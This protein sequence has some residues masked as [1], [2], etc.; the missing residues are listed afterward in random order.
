MNVQV[1]NNLAR[2]IIA[3]DRPNNR[4]D[5]SQPL[6][7]TVK[8]D[9]LRQY[10]HLPIVE[11]AK[12]LGTCTT[13]LKKIC[14]KNKIKKWPYRQIR[15][16]TKSVQSLEMASMN[17]SL[18]EDLR[19]QYREQIATLQRAIDDLIRDPN[20]SINLVDMRVPVEEND[21]QDI[22]DP[23]SGTGSSYPT[24]RSDGMIDNSTPS[25]WATEQAAAFSAASGSSPNIPLSAAMA[26]QQQVAVSTS[27][28]LILQPSADVNQIMLAAAATA[29][30]EATSR[31]ASSMIKR[32]TSSSNGSS[33]AINQLGTGNTSGDGGA[34]DGQGGAKQKP[35]LLQ[36]QQ[37]QQPP[38]QEE[39]I[40]NNPLIGTTIVSQLTYTN[41][42]RHRIIY[43]PPVH[44]APLQR[45]KLNTSK[46]L[47]PLIE[48]D[49]CNNFDMDFLPQSILKKGDGGLSG[50]LPVSSYAEGG[51][52]EA[53]GG[54]GMDTSSQT[55]GGGGGN[56]MGMS[57]HSG[58]SYQDMGDA[59]RGSL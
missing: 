34:V 22:G 37:Q 55:S 28:K 4:T 35:Q 15:S 46:K 14:R 26:S 25:L 50:S 57:N 12:Q 41:P 24:S 54:S 11:V 59:Y 8:L 20:T 16:I 27:Q 30:I 58:V 1:D 2:R 29:G 31:Y 33:S 42:G 32:R 6:S 17:D 39:Q 18:Q 3:N 53:V 5:G 10:F 52:G 47:V 38:Q 49:I 19:I 7:K 13:A 36:Q 45:R 51:V 21:E 40:Q 9:D 43:M 44:L 48:P 23:G 56:V